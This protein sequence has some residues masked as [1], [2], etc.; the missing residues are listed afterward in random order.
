MSDRAGTLAG[1]TRAEIVRNVYLRHQRP[2][3]AAVAPLDES[4]MRARP[5]NAT[6]IA[7]NLWHVAR[8]ADW[9]QSALVSSPEGL[10]TRIG[11]RVAA[12]WG[13]AEATL[14]TSQTG[15]GM[16]DD[17]SAELP[18]PPKADLVAY[19]ERAFTAVDD[20]L[21]S[22]DDEALDAPASIP[23]D[24]TPWMS[25]ADSST[26]M[27]WILVY[28]DHGGRHLGMVETLRG[29]AGLRGTATV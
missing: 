17:V 10:R 20:L 4:Q 21:A 28:L 13:L 24:R 11:P 26:V 9:L 3:L 18:L 14:G 7:F 22:L 12:R 23:L 25:A 15:M 27:Q 19:A 16:D 6:S 1:V 5:G 8:W 2:L 29:I